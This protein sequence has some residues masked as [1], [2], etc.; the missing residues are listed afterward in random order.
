[1]LPN[2]KSAHL[3]LFSWYIRTLVCCL[4][5]K[6]SSKMISIYNKQL[7]SFSYIYNNLLYTY[8]P[9]FAHF[10][11]LVVGKNSEKNDK[12]SFP[13]TYL[14][15]ARVYRLWENFLCENVFFGVI[16][17]FQEFYFHFFVVFPWLLQRK[18]TKQINNTFISSTR[19]ER[20]K[21]RQRKNRIN[22]HFQS[23]I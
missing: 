17:E 3:L 2:E 21:G 18:Q 1:M 7:F 14:G 6:T 22:C 5:R 20:K 8:I 23:V 4:R 12:I 11:K 16:N 13:S 19:K 9:I 15:S 10:C